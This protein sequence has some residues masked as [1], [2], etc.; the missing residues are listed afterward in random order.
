MIRS[1]KSRSAPIEEWILYTA[2]NESDTSNDTW[3]REVISKNLRKIKRLDVLICG[4]TDHLK[5]DY[6][7]GVPRNS[8]RKSQPGTCRRCGNTS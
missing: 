1:L 2:D 3:I 7:Q 8:N 4:K 6:R 5:R